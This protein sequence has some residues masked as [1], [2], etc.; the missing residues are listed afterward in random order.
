MLSSKG[1]ETK[2]LIREA[3]FKLFLTKDYKSVSLKDIENITKMTRGGTSYHYHTKKDIFIDVINV[4]ILDTQKNK[5]LENDVCKMSVYDYLNC[6]VDNISITMKNLSKFLIDGIN[7]NGTRAYMS[8]ILQAEKYYPG[9][10]K[11]L[12]DIE[13]VE[14]NNLKEIIQRGKDS[15]E[16]REDC[17]IDLLSK[18]I[19]LLFVGQSYYDA[20]KNGLNAFE[21]REHLLYL[22]YLVQNK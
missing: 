9:F 17:N 19:R 20:L 2:K 11:L 18:Q 1:T 3:A 8:L 15:G 4:Y 16:I 13:N 10:H 7:I 6:Y 22:Y 5:H 14:I 12:N 21:L